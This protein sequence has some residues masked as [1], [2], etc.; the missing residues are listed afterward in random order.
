M[1]SSDGLYMPIAKSGSVVQL[2]LVHANVC[3]AGSNLAEAERL[4]TQVLQQAGDAEGDTADFAAIAKLKLAELKHVE[5]P[6]DAQ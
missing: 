5:N 1:S 2:N 3:F 6:A 4:Y